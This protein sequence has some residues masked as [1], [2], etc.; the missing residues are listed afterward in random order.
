MYFEPFPG[1]SIHRLASDATK[2]KA[3]EFATNKEKF[4]AKERK[5]AV[6]YAKVEQNDDDVQAAKTK[7]EWKAL[8][9][10]KAADFALLRDWVDSHYM[11]ELRGILT[12]EANRLPDVEAAV[13]EKLVS[14]GFAN[15]LE[16]RGAYPR[17]AVNQHV[18]VRD[19]KD[20]IADVEGALDNCRLLMG[21]C[22]AAEQ[23]I[24]SRLASARKKTL[25]MF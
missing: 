6:G 11:P 15:S 13:V 16:G 1:V 21:S 17:A 19:Q 20:L 4:D 12:T 14:I 9:K 22:V 10:E 3:A 5:W 7:T 23:R 2:A 18:A 25:A 24:E 8:Q